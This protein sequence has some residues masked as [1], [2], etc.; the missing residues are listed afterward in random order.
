M[1]RKTVCTVYS[2]TPFAGPFDDGDK[3]SI[4]DMIRENYELKPEDLI[5]FVN[6]PDLYD[7]EKVMHVLEETAK[8][9]L[10]AHGT[11]QQ[12]TIL[13]FTQMEQIRTAIENGKGDTWQRIGQALI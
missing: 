9:W 5:V 11:D 6:A 8:P 7:P 13:P 1:D 10:I 3:D 4:A 2:L 12:F